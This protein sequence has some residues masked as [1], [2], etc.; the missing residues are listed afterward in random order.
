MDT[1]KREVLIDLSSDKSASAFELMSS[2]GL[3]SVPFSNSCKLS[4]SMVLSNDI[5]DIVSSVTVSLN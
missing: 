4:F 1:N 2:K 3:S 5:D